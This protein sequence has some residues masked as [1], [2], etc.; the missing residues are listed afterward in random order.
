ML[1]AVRRASATPTAPPLPTSLRTS[2]R[3]YIQLLTRQAKP[4]SLSCSDCDSEEDMADDLPSVDGEPSSDDDAPKKA[5]PPRPQSSARSPPSSTRAQNGQFSGRPGVIDYDSAD[6][7]YSDEEKT[8]KGITM[9]MEG[10]DWSRLDHCKDVVRKCI[11]AT[12]GK[13]F[14]TPSRTPDFDAFFT[15]VAA[16]GVKTKKKGG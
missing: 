9:A 5:P 12:M 4:P 14:I 15:H 10:G 6:S 11:S 8:L 7:S 13:Q 16:P 2:D 3:L 1:C